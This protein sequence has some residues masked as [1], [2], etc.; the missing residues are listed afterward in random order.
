M[1]KLNTKANFR[2]T[3]TSDG[4]VGSI[5]LEDERSYQCHSLTSKE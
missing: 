1:E 3:V 4:R 2:V 5:I